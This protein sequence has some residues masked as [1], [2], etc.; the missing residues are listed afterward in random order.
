MGGSQQDCPCLWIYL[1]VSFLA[2]ANS[3]KLCDHRQPW[4]GETLVYVACGDRRFR[5]APQI[6]ATLLR[7]TASRGCCRN[8][9][10][11]E[12]TD[13][14]NGTRKAGT[15]TLASQSERNLLDRPTPHI[16]F[17]DLLL[18][19]GELLYRKI[20]LRLAIPRVHMQW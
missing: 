15:F 17:V 3:W 1:S 12:E 2:I 6:L 16:R 4:A 20:F 7:K 5:G 9:Q 18:D 14:Y 19:N 8:S 11:R 13:N 10:K